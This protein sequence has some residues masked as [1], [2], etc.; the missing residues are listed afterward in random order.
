MSGNVVKAKKRR[1]RRI[2]ERLYAPSKWWHWI[3]LFLT[4]YTLA[5]VFIWFFVAA[6]IC[7]L[8]EAAVVA[9]IVAIPIAAYH[10]L[11]T[12]KERTQQNST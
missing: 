6:F 10:C 12:R 8:V 9:L 5:F 11:Q 2:G 1:R 4:M 7:L 3:L